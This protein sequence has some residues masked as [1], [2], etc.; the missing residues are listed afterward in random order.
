MNILIVDHDEG[1]SLL[2]ATTLQSA[3]HKVITVRSKTEALAHLN[4]SPHLDILFIDPSPQVQARQMMIQ[5]RRMVP[6]YVYTILTGS[7][8]SAEAGRMAGANHIAAKPYDHQHVLKVTEQA[9]RMLRI[10]RHLGDLS[11][12]FPS[13][14]GIIAKSAF[15]QLFSIAFDRADRYAE[16]SCMLF[17]RM[18]NLTQVRVHDSDYAA[19]VTS[20][21][22]GQMI[23]RFHRTTD[24][25]AQTGQTEYALLLQRPAYELEPVDAAMRFADM[26]SNC[27]DLMTATRIP[28]EI[29]VDVIHIPTGDL[30]AH[31]HL[32]VQSPESAALSQR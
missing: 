5:I 22:L 3:G 7:G 6:N 9:D 25:L 23:A 12:D 31:H 8:I 32:L 14:G 30:T 15:W 2:L 10:R 28:I 21:T 20:A 24:I 17:I 16:E 13:G 11:E 26:L 1:A 18:I 27:K 29:E 4:T 19:Q